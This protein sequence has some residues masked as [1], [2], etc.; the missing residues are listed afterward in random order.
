MLIWEKMDKAVKIHK[1][2]RKEEL[3]AYQKKYGDSHTK[4]EKG[5]LP[6]ML[7]SAFLVLL[8]SSFLIN[9]VQSKYCISWQL[10]TIYPNL[11]RRNLRRR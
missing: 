3:E 8:P 2:E 1:E 9:H 4:L 5:D 11:N 7:L 10:K 6:A